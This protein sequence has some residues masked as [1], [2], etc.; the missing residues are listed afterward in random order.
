MELRHNQTVDSLHKIFNH[1]FKGLPD[2]Q[3]KRILLTE[4]EYYNWTTGLYLERLDE[5]RRQ[6]EMVI[7]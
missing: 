5:T 4:G 2:P 7:N 1:A 6:T 3:L